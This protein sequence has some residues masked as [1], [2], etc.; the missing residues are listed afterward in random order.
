MICDLTSEQ[1]DS[2]RLNSPGVN[3]VPIEAIEFQGT[4]EKV[5]VGDIACGRDQMSN[6][7]SGTSTDV[8]PVGV[9][10]HYGSI[11]EKFAVDRRRVVAVIFVQYGCPGSWLEK[12]NGFVCRDVKTL[13]PLNDRA[14]TGRDSSR[15]PMPIDVDVAC[16]NIFSAGARS[17]SLGESAHTQREGS[18]AYHRRE[19][20][21]GCARVS[22]A[23]NDVFV[24]THA[25]GSAPQ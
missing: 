16:G 21:P 3:Y 23:F 20:S 4:C 12:A 17:G 22:F 9:G 8:D 19:L 10:D 5:F 15:V 6:V 1:R 18:E 2:V 25:L 7:Q 14:V 11:G 24:V 13:A